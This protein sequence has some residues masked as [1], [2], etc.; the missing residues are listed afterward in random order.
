MKKTKMLKK[1]YEFKNV[2]SKG[3]YIPGKRINAYI[4]KNK[5]DINLLGLAISVKYG[6]AFK[7]NRIKRVLREVYS[8]S[9]ED[10]LNQGISIIFLCKKNAKY[11]EINFKN[12]EKDMYLIFDKAKVLKS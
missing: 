1:N 11:E 9:F 12:I 8:K 4:A 10:K 5:K 3:A 2:L 6:K 7:R